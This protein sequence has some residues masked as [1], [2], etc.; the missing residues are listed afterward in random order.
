MKIQD[1][2]SLLRDNTYYASLFP[3]Q[4]QNAIFEYVIDE[5]D[6][7]EEI[8]QYT[9]HDFFMTEFFNKELKSINDDSSLVSRF[10]VALMSCCKST[11]WLTEIN[12]KFLLKYIPDFFQVYVS[13]NDVMTAI[14]NDGY[15]LKNKMKGLKRAGFNL[16]EIKSFCL[17]PCHKTNGFSNYENNLYLY[18]VLRP[19]IEHENDIKKLEQYL[20]E[21]IRINLADYSKESYYP[22][23]KVDG[24]QYRVSLPD[25]EINKFIALIEGK[26]NWD[27]DIS[28]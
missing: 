9:V 8:K 4:A 6:N 25:V 15:S 3:E 7:L 21:Y 27:G 28:S 16:E 20:L 26:G 10:I 2:I 14:F 17:E 23:D 1:A 18:Y 12:I 11:A 24:S 19:L 22:R 5:K 13:K